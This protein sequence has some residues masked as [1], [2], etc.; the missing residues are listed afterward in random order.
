M[1]PAAPQ[2]SSKVAR[3]RMVLAALVAF[4]TVVAMGY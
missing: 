4:V 1:A 3:Y 2:G